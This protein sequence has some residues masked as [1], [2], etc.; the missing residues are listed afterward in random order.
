MQGTFDSRH[1]HGETAT[2][3]G[4]SKPAV[5]VADPGFSDETD[6]HEYLLPA[7]EA[8]PCI[9]KL[10]VCRTGGG[11]HEKCGWEMH[12]NSDL[13]CFPQR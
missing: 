6:T 3:D 8:N 5:I 2:G 13:Y 7:K 9:S 10:D 4:S 11:R 12:S 1:E